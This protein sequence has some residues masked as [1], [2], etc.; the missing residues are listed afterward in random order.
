MSKKQKPNYY[1]IGK[2]LTELASKDKSKGNIESNIYKSYIHVFMTLPESDRYVEHETEA[3][4][5]IEDN[6]NINSIDQEAT[7]YANEIAT[8][9]KKLNINFGINIYK[10]DEYTKLDLERLGYYSSRETK[11]KNQLLCPHVW[12]E[13][14]R[15][16]PFPLELVLSDGQI[17]SDSDNNSSVEKCRDTRKGLQL[18]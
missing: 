17:A 13:S 2:K 1:E 7:E 16:I 9:L 8:H 12:D 4:P 11:N 18:K 6:E 14:G 10:V 3:T 5:E 15:N